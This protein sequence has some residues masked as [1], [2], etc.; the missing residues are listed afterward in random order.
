MYIEHHVLYI[1]SFIMARQIANPVVVAKAERMAKATGMTK[2]AVVEKANDH[3][4]RKTQRGW[5]PGRLQALLAQVDQVPARA[6]AFEAL[7]WDELG[8]PK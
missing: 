4:A 5:D 7:E 8:L 6:E 3:L 1:W 2:T